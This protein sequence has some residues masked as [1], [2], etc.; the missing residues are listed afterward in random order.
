M[1][2]RYIFGFAL[3]VLAFTFLPADVVAQEGLVTCQGTEDSPCNFCSFASTVVNV[4]DFVTVLLI[5]VAVVILAVTGI[6]IAASAGSV[7]AKQILKERITNIIIGFLLII[8]S[9]AII[10]TVMKSLVAPDTDLV[11]KWRTS[12]QD[13]GL[14][15]NVIVP[16]ETAVDEVPGGS[17]VF[18]GTGGDGLPTQDVTDSLE[19]LGIEY[20]T[21]KG[22]A[23]FE[24]LKPHVIGA[25]SALD[26]ACQCNVFITE[27]TGGSHSS[28]AYSHAN[29]YKLDLRTKDNPELVSYV[30]KLPPAGNWK[31]GTKLYKDENSCATYAVESDHIDVVYLPNCSEV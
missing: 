3:L 18:A 13:L 17:S 2:M 5:I 27:A 24:G 19:R 11:T 23:G 9:W 26:Q 8:A 14:C 15:V 31:D 21:G 1:I 30:K 29:G 28:G 4:V 10:D 16:S 22:A 6:Q 20:K 12:I 25:V 7:D